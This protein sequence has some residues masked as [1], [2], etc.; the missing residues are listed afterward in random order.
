[1]KEDAFREYVAAAADA[2]ETNDWPSADQKW[3]R[4]EGSG[5]RWYLRVAP[6][7]MYF[8]PC[9][10][11]AMVQLS[12]GQ[13][14]RRSRAWKRKLALVESQMEQKL[15]SLA[16]RTYRARNV[17]FKAPDFVNIILNAGDARRPTGAY[18]GQSLPRQGPMVQAGKQR[19]LAFSNLYSDLDSR[20]QLKSLADNYFCAASATIFSSEPKPRIIAAVLNDASR[21]L[22]PTSDYLLKGKTPDEV[23]GGMLAT[24][25][26]EL[27]A[28]A[29]SMYFIGW[30]KDKELIEPEVAHQV[31]AFGVIGALNYI[32]R[33]VFAPDGRRR[34]HGHA[35]ALQ[36]GA[37]IEGGALEWRPNEN[38]AAGHDRGCFSMNVE[39]Y[40]T[41]TESLVATAVKVKASGD[42]QAAEALLSKYVDKGDKALF[43]T[44]MARGRRQPKASFVYSVRMGDRI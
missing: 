4:M 19:T 9:G 43:D 15:A 18:I 6:D 24:I 36:L 28:Q 25:L 33:G 37:L 32:S 3:V 22:G 44:I 26:E 17:D 30:L 5:S 34:V 1:G 13:V 39:R 12:F 2:F 7:E 40:S 23:F 20:A 11:K 16:G 10:R 41:S 14:D 38:T 31:Y 27:K 8:S 29:A 42:R 35:G 21:N